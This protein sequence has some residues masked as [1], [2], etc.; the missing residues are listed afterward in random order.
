MANQIP[1][2]PILELPQELILRVAAYL[3][4][5]ELGALR[6]TCHG[7]ETSLFDSFAREFFTKRQF[8]LEQNSLEALVGIA[9]HP[10]LSPYL[11]GK[12]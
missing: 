7:I 6:R 2:S 11:T 9:D 3:N 12:R 4:T 1:P 8:M 5:V 10:T